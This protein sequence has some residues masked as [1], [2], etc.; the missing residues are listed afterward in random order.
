MHGAVETTVAV[1][2][3]A[4]VLRDDPRLGEFACDLLA[5]I[6]GQQAEAERR[7]E[8]RRAV[9]AA[10][11]K[12]FDRGRDGFDAACMGKPLDQREDSRCDSV[13]VAGVPPPQKPLD[14]D[15]IALEQLDQQRATQRLGIVGNGCRVLVASQAEV[16]INPADRPLGLEHRCFAVSQKNLEDRQRGM[17]ASGPHRPVVAQ[18]ADGFWIPADTH[19]VG[20]V[21]Q[22]RIRSLRRT[23]DTD[24]FHRDTGE[25]VD[26]A[27]ACRGNGSCLDACALDRPIGDFAEVGSDRLIDEGKFDQGLDA[28]ELGQNRGK[29]TGGIDGLAL[30][31]LE[32]GEQVVLRPVI[33]RDHLRDKRFR[34][35]VSENQSGCGRRDQREEIGHEAFD[36]ACVDR[37]S[38]GQ[39]IDWYR[40]RQQSQAGEQSPNVLVARAAH[41]RRLAGR[42]NLLGQQSD[43]S[44]FAVR[45][46]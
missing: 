26:L 10:I 13:G 1:I 18:T 21:A 3:V 39:L 37:Q 35:L 17:P 4:C 33:L 9:S 44:L 19:N 22:E 31:L 40:R 15:A 6:V 12:R 11:G 36:L 29:S 43:Q 23:P 46:C 20:I 5:R 38:C 25:F 32:P 30:P 41:D 45:R 14:P 24:R 28:V 27:G 7:C 42:I 8:H 16:T 2:V 34:W